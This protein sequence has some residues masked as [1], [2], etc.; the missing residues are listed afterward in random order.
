[1]TG[2]GGMISIELKGGLE[3]GKTLLNNVQVWQLAVS[4]GGVESLIQHPASMTHAS[5]GPEARKAAQITDGLIRISVGI[6]NVDELI[7]GLEAGLSKI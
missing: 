3:A 2:F 5:M 1:M 4:L 7:K 6:E